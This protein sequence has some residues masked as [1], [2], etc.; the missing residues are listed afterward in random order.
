MTTYIYALECPET[1][2]IRYVGKADDLIKRY[3]EHGRVGGS[4]EKMRWIRSLRAKG[5]RPN[6][7]VLEEAPWDDWE[8]IERWWIK[9]LRA[10]GSPLL[11]RCD[12]G[13]GGNRI[14]YY[15]PEGMPYTH[16]A[17]TLEFLSRKSKN[18]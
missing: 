6:L 15:G 4:H 10:H 12:G 14:E 13:R 7:I 18:S 5:L 3:R 2:E 16:S 9:E 17:L 11:N 8:D 1:K